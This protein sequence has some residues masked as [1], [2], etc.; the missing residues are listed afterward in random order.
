MNFVLPWLSVAPALDPLSSP[1]LL[2]L[3]PPTRAVQLSPGGSALNPGAIFVAAPAVARAGIALLGQVVTVLIALRA[4]AT[5]MDTT[6]TGLCL[7][8]SL[9]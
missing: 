7:A 6:E 1:C 9:H 8:L 4:E 2:L 5:R 3:L